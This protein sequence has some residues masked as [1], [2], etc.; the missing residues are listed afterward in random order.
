MLL[1]TWQV[2]SVLRALRPWATWRNGYPGHHGQRTARE[3]FEGLLIQVT[4]LIACT[5]CAC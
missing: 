4:F 5:V 3:P 2:Q 1:Q